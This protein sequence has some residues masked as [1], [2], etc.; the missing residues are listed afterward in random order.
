MD[1]MSQ[2]ISIA[3]VIQAVDEKMDVTNCGG[4]GDCFNG[5]MCLTH[6]LWDDLSKQLYSFLNSITLASLIDQEG[7][8]VEQDNSDK[9]QRIE[10]KVLN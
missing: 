1:R 5:E 2:E 7:I 10:L 9:S 8:K 4:K 3:E 6:H